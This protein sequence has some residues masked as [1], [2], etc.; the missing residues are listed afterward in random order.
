MSTFCYRMLN[1]KTRKKNRNNNNLKCFRSA[2]RS[3]ITLE[4]N[5]VI[6]TPCDVPKVIF[7]CR[8]FITTTGNDA[9]D[10]VYSLQLICRD[11]IPKRSNRKCLNV[12][13]WR[14]EKRREEKRKEEKR[15]EVKRKERRKEEGS[16]LDE[17]FFPFI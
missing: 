2:W 6:K 13:W 3:V 17:G 15:R 16:R 11:I 9:S 5:R 7:A 8:M 4:W 12:T 1:D 14:E 10:A